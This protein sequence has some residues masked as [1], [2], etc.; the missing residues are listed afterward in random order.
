MV[1]LPINKSAGPLSFNTLTIGFNPSIAL[2]AFTIPASANSAI[3]PCTPRSPPRFLTIT[4]SIL[5]LA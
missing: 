3:K 5:S 4:S 1:F 2:L